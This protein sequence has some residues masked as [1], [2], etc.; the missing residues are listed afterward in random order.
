[1]GTRCNVMIKFSDTKIILYRHYDG[2][3]EVTGES[4][5]NKLRLAER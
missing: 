3:L 2:Y 1:M 4:V 5:L